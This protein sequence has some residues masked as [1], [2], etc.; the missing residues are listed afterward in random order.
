MWWW[1]GN[2]HFRNREDLTEEEARKCG[3][4]QG[5]SFMGEVGGRECQFRERAKAKHRAREVHLDSA[6]SESAA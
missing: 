3:L 6:S 4:P 1:R 2:C 5:Y